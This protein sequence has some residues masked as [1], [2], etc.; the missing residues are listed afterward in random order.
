MIKVLHCLSQ[1]PGKT[2]SGIYL[3]AL[4][5]EGHKLGLDQWLIC[6]IPAS[7]PK[8]EIDQLANHHI[9][10]IIFDSPDLPF[11]VA[12]MSDVMPYPSSRFSSF[13]HDSLT[14]YERAF[15]AKIKEV[16]ELIHPDIIHSHHLWLMT[17]L[18]R[19]LFPKVP[20]VTT[21]HGTDLRQL[22]LADHLA[23]RA[24]A[25]C[26]EVD[27]VMAL[28]EE[29]KN[30]II[31]FYRLNE[32][33]LVITG[34]GFRHELFNTNQCSKGSDI[35]LIY[36]GKLSRAKGVPWLLEAVGEIENITLK[37]A[38]G[39]EGEEADNIRQ[40]AKKLA[41]KVELLGAL[42]QEALAEEFKKSHIFVLP[43]FYEGLP[44]VLLEALACGCRVVMNDLPGIRDLFPSEALDKGLISLV[45]L[46]GII[47]SDVP[48]TEDLPLFVQN[49]RTAIK[50]Q[51]NEARQQQTF[52]CLP[53]EETLQE[54]TWKRVFTR[55]MKVYQ[56]VL[57]QT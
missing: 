49:L 28:N 8:V 14:L 18:I 26:Q 30:K 11:P 33:Q 5:R 51:I 53:L 9:F 7:M 50:E 17:A 38:G 12:G 22:Q 19:R 37:L 1:I 52:C 54:N 34:S 15:A 48:K 25:G 16:V 40:Q 20:L 27:K 43:S 2:G 41:P 24:I 36:A 39:G 3:Q 55:V 42:S 45:T 29:Q 4:V 6:G 13:N 21:S 57:K 23:L 32:Q 35:K 47:G 56:E 10:P 44:L 46:P 31:D